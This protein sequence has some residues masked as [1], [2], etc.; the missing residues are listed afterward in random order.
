MKLSCVRKTNGKNNI[1]TYAQQ[2]INYF[3][4]AKSSKKKVL[5]FT[6]EKTRMNDKNTYRRTKKTC[7][8]AFT[9]LLTCDWAIWWILFHT[10]GEYSASSTSLF[11]GYYWG[12]K[13]KKFENELFFHA[14]FIPFQVININYNSVWFINLID[15]FFFLLCVVLS[16]KYILQYSRNFES[17]C[18]KLIV[19]N[20]SFLSLFF[21]F[22]EIET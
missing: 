3:T 12:K 22:C 4:N 13:M 20:I 14:Y 5:K 19:A 7:V 8:H 18:W 21:P 17:Y 16:I 6:V 15:V 1:N 11:F 9:Y 10:M 2:W